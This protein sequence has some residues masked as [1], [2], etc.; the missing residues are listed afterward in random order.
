M[1]AGYKFLLAPPHRN[2]KNT[3]IGGLGFLLSPWAQRCYI[4]HQSISNN[5]MSVSFTGQVKTHIINCHSPTNV[6]PD[7]EIDDF[8]G[9][10]TDLVQSFPPHDLVII[11]ADFNAHIGKDQTNHNAYYKDTNRNGQHLLNFCQENNLKISSTKFNKKD[12]KKVTWISPKGQNHQIDHI[13]IRSKWQNSMKNAESYTSP[14]VASDHRIVTANFKLSLRKNIT[15][16]KTSKYDWSLLSDSRI[17]SN[18]NKSFRNRFSV[19]TKD[20]EEDEEGL[21]KNST[22]I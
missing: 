14:S 18:F 13:L 4:D 12:S 20:L 16:E 17:L 5:I 3:T 1:K 7:Q 2:T 22:V 9:L 6:S 8:Y 10:L 19:L 21:M 11:A 15:K